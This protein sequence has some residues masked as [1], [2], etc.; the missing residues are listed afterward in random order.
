MNS[1]RALGFSPAAHAGVRLVEV[2]KQAE[3]DPLQPPPRMTV[4][5]D[6][7]HPT[8]LRED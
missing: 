5:N 4:E 7:R 6:H 8:K 2:P 3:P 1:A